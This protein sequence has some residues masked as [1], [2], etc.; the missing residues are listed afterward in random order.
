MQIGKLNREFGLEAKSTA[1][2]IHQQSLEGAQDALELFYYGFNNKDL[3]ALKK[4]WYNKE[5]IQLNNPVGG[6]IRGIDSI[7]QLYDTIFS[8]EATVWVKLTDIVYYITP[9]MAVFAGTEIGEFE[10][11]DETIPLKIRTSRVFYYPENE[12][13]WYQVHHHGS[14]DNP[15]LLHSYQAAIKK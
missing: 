13:R 3:E 2:Y 10:I 5:L 14:I 11:N 8:G 12:R 1:A 6:I 15:G 7:M 4:V 9:E